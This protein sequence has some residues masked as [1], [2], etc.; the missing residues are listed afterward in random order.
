MLTRACS[1]VPPAGRMVHHPEFENAGLQPGL[2]VWRV[3]QFNLVP[4]PD[5]LH[6][7]FYT[8][9]AYVILNTIKQRSGALQYDLHF[10]LGKSLTSGW[11]GV[12]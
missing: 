11:A 9:D 1:F 8:G 12:I 2:Q 3:E 5:N 6:G 4:V 7:G 10:W